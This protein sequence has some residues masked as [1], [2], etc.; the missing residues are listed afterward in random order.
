MKASE[1]LTIDVPAGTYNIP[2]T[3][4]LGVDQVPYDTKTHSWGWYAI[5]TLF[6]GLIFNMTILLGMSA[7]V[8]AG[9]N[10]VQITVAMIF[11]GL[12]TAVLF[13]LN[14]FGG[15]KY[16][17]NHTVQLR[18]AFGNMVGSY[19][20]TILRAAIA[21]IWYGIQSWLIA[22]CF[23]VIL[24][25][26]T[27]WGGL[28]Y[29]PR[30]FPLFVV[31]TGIQYAFIHW[32]YKGLKIIA[33]WGAPA[34]FLGL[35]GMIVWGRMTAGTWGPIL[36]QEGNYAAWAPPGMFF[37]AMALIIAGY[38]TVAINISDITRVFKG[39]RRTL[40]AGLAFIPLGW[41]TSGCLAFAMLSMAFAMGWGPIWNP[42]EWIGKFPIGIFA[43]VV[44]ILVMAAGITTNAP[45]NILSPITTMTNLFKKLS[46][47]NAAIIA[48]VISLA[49]FPWVFLANP[50]T[51]LAMV[52][53]FGGTLGGIVGIMI[54]DW[55]VFRKN[56]P[57]LAQL[58]EPNGIYK[59]WK[60][61]INWIGI[62]SLIVSGA[63]GWLFPQWGLFISMAVGALVYYVV[64][65]AMRKT[66]RIKRSLP[67]D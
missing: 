57:D 20:P 17:I 48:S 2:K 8:L 6:F 60:G 36:L 31:A 27:G 66:E 63:C 45:A 23:D 40:Y 14:S 56:R 33:Q 61:G 28:A 3:K 16:G 5:S 21:I 51:F 41:I 50:D 1:K 4:L 39:E 64:T 19:I 22:M 34:C 52:S 13:W 49:T 53:R 18:S 43:V 29:L 46:F 26:F 11:G 42:I 12:L 9:L 35:V 62:G 10:W 25:A 54:V 55:W 58:Y 47:R 24:S 30:M 44:L 7:L 65:F 37:F 59:Y 67:S 15:T 38:A 32:E